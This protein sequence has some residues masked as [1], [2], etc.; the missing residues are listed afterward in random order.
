MTHEIELRK[1]LVSF[2]INQRWLESWVM[3]FGVNN[4]LRRK[5]IRNIRMSVFIIFKLA[6]LSGQKQFAA[7]RFITHEC[8]DSWKPSNM[9]INC[10][11]NSIACLYFFRFVDQNVLEL[12]LHLHHRHRTSLSWNKI[13]IHIKSINPNS[14][15]LAFYSHAR[16]RIEA[17]I[18]KRL[19]K[20][21]IIPRHYSKAENR[22]REFCASINLCLGNIFPLHKKS[23]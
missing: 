21:A 9:N 20:L 16:L 22:E 18:K 23:M 5:E 7:D 6:Q 13:I 1:C 15:F 19:L 4:V 10:E 8:H 2:F 11:Y 12:F 14:I 17:T 3:W